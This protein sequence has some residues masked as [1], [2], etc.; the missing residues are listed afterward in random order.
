[1][2]QH[3]ETLG[4]IIQDQIEASQKEPN[5]SETLQTRNNSVAP[6]TLIA[7][8]DVQDLQVPTYVASTF[9]REEELIVEPKQQVLED[10]QLDEVDKIGTNVFSTVEE[11]RVSFATLHPN[12]DFVIPNIFTDVDPKALLVSALPKVV[13]AFKQASSARILILIHFKTQGRVFSNHGS[14]MRQNLLQIIFRYWI[15]ILKSEFEFFEV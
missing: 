1:M 14:L 8:M 6:P 11:M 15:S 3:I 5:N 10:T 2:E 13:P 12:I 7:T 4:K 9:M